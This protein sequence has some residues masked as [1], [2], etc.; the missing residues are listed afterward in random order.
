MDRVPEVWTP[1][2]GIT[3]IG[4]FT[5]VNQKADLPTRMK[6]IT[7]GNTSIRGTLSQSHFTEQKKKQKRRPRES[8]EKPVSQGH[9]ATT[10]ATSNEKAGATNT[11]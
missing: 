3:W 5:I 2:R 1:K 6:S 8:K 4:S 9:S 11:D 7:R 10:T